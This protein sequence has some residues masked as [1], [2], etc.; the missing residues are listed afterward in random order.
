MRRMA[1]RRPRP[2][3]A[4]RIGAGRAGVL[5]VLAA[6]ALAEALALGALLRG[7]W[8][9]ALAL[10]LACV[11]AALALRP[12]AARG[13]HPAAVL[14]LVASLL[15]VLG[16]AA[17]LGG[18]AA[19]LLAAPRDAAV[20]ALPDDPVEARLAAIAAARDLP[21]GLLLEALGDVLRWGTGPQKARAADL[22]AESLRPGGE[23]LLRLALLDPDAGLRARA[24]AARPAAERRL[25]A[26]AAALRAAAAQAPADMAR[27]RALARHL[28]GAAYSGL[29]DPAQAAA[30]RTEA[31]AQ[32]RSLAEAVPADAEAP[33][34]LGRGLLALGDLG[35]ARGA[36]EA[37]LARSVATPAVLGW[38]AECLYR[39]RDL[40]ALDALLA[41]WRPILEAEATGHAPLSPAW[42]LWLAEERAS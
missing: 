12:P 25:V 10:H 22:A 13:G 6:L 31:V 8:P 32:W 37:A 28:D 38:L 17:V 42:R 4:K 18:L 24:E 9:P 16:P 30:F 20:E 34:A 33:A 36:L 35:A 2:D 39:A 5:P 11:V 1:E 21:D 29:L 23:A 26:A 27:R 14:R 3:A 19:L 15:P 41:R 7:W 40:P